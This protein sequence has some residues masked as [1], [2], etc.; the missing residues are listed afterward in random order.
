MSTQLPTGTTTRSTKFQSTS[1][2]VPKSVLTRWEP[3]LMGKWRTREDSPMRVY[4]FLCKPFAMQALRERRLKIARLAEMNDPFEMLPFD[5]SNRVQRIAALTT[6]DRR[7]GTAGVLC[8]SKS[9]TNP[10]VWSHYTDQHRGV[11][12]GF[13][14]ADNL[15]KPIRYAALREP[16]PCRRPHSHR[17]KLLLLKRPGPASFQPLQDKP[18]SPLLLPCAAVLPRCNGSQAKI[19]LR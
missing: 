13:D 2:S 5:M 19:G 11:C 6:L 10:V 15:T 3:A 12:L 1:G 18:A 9:W 14:T 4:K 7:N 8:F 17:R 16:L